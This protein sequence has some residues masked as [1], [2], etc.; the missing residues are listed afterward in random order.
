MGDANTTERT[1]IRQQVIFMQTR[2]QPCPAEE[3]GTNDTRCPS[4]GLRDGEDRQSTPERNL[5]WL[6]VL[7][8][9]LSFHLSSGSQHVSPFWFHFPIATWQ[10]HCW[11]WIVSSVCQSVRSL[12]SRLALCDLEEP[13]FRHCAVLLLKLTECGMALSWFWFAWLMC[14]IPILWVMQCYHLLNTFQFLLTDQLITTV[15][16]LFVVL[17]GFVLVSVFCVSLGFVVVFVGFLVALHGDSSMDY[18]SIHPRFFWCTLS[19]W[20]CCHCINSGSLQNATGCPD[21]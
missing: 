13:W 17:L 15:P 1:V 20:W 9:R 8:P 4:R 10:C 14:A 12:P 19:S 2:V 11:H 18:V 16:W 21:W 5:R 7:F 3:L 6:W